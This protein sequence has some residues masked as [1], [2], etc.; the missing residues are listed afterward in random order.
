MQ[1][2]C[3]LTYALDG[4]FATF[5][6]LVGFE[7][8]AGTRGRVKCRVVADGKELFTK[9]DL[10]PSDKP[11]TIE[12]PIV[13]VKELI[14]E[15]DFGEDED[16]ADRIIWANPRLYRETPPPATAAAK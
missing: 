13:G 9:P 10:R 12:A 1:S 4:Q 3:V 16:V 7:D 15:V 5:K 6:T 11:Q 14:L 8:E 2:R